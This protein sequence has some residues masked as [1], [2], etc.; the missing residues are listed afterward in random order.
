MLP[1]T[2]PLREVISPVITQ[3][4][5]PQPGVHQNAVNKSGTHHPVIVGELTGGIHRRASDRLRLSRI[6][7]WIEGRDVPREPIDS[8]PRRWEHLPG[9]IL[10]KP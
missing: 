5:S 2:Q 4:S 3:P 6:K 8:L 9:S 1:F 10:G 7:R